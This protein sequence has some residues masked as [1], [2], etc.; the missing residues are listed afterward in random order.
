[1]Y[2][3]FRHVVPISPA[4]TRSGQYQ[5]IH[6]PRHAHVAKTPLFF[7]LVGLVDCPRMG[8]ETFFH[9]RQE[10]QRKLQ[11]LGGMQAHQRDP[12]LGIVTIRVTH[13]CGV[14]EE[15]R[16]GLAPLLRVLRSVGKLLQ[17]F[18]AGERFRCPFFLERTDVAS[19][20][21]QKADQF[22][23]CGCIAG[24]AESFMGNGI[25][26][27]KERLIRFIK[28]Q[29]CL[30]LG[31]YIGG[32][33]FQVAKVETDILPLTRFRFCGFR[34]ARL[35]LGDDVLRKLLGKPRLE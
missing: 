25:G 1:M 30:F 5:G 8:K 21:D 26:C 23:K 17:V 32:L 27:W 31:V 10:H 16:K 14:I 29:Q 34:G 13:Q 7:E 18:N 22:R 3:R 33:R 11:T 6:G 2:A 20:V 15:L 24:L 28:A 19:A 4:I 35:R 9:A 12:A